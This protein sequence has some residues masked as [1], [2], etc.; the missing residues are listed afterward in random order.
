MHAPPQK[1][2][3]QAVRSRSPTTA[4]AAESHY[5]YEHLGDFV[6]C[7]SPDGTLPEV[8]MLLEISSD[9]K[10]TA[11][12]T[13]PRT[14]QQ[15]HY[16]GLNTLSGRELHLNEDSPRTGWDKHDISAME[17]RYARERS[18]W[19]REQL[20]ACIRAANL[21]IEL[22]KRSA[23]S[24]VARATEQLR[25]AIDWARGRPNLNQSC[26]TSPVQNPSNAP[27]P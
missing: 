14:K 15:A 23:D 6:V 2:S 3:A 21:A 24:D 19:T 22:A 11:I 7:M 13:D 4:E 18:D 5:T 10:L 26:P 17:A 16:D 27:L 8:E 9:R 12:F 25:K 1:R 20:D